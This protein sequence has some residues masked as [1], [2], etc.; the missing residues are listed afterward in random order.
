MWILR[1]FSE[2]LY[3]KAP[4]RNFLF[5]LQPAEFEQ[6]DTLKNYLTGAFQASLGKN[7]K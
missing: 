2:E 3:Y 1:S 7:K 4:L 6:A 5:H